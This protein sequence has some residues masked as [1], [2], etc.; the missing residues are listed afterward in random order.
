L[1]TALLLSRA[2][3]PQWRCL[4]FGYEAF[5][6][7]LED[8]EARHFSAAVT[9]AFMPPNC[10]VWSR[11]SSQSSAFGLRRVSSYIPR[12]NSHIR[13]VLAQGVWGAPG[14]HGATS[15]NTPAKQR[16]PARATSNPRMN[17][18]MTPGE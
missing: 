11:I 15:F 6:L 16:W 1:T 7:A 2:G 10:T 3:W 13:P 17:N 9:I 14:N 8:E 4:S 5:H 12:R 18:C